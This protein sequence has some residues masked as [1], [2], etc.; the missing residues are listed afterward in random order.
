MAK[1]QAV[2]AKSEQN[3]KTL[4]DE[5]AN[6]TI[7]QEKLAEWCDQDKDKGMC[8][9][10][11]TAV[12]VC[13]VLK[14]A[15]PEAVDRKALAA[16]MEEVMARAVRFPTAGLMREQGSTD[17][18]FIQKSEELL[19]SP[20]NKH[21]FFDLFEQKETTPKPKPLPKPR[22]LKP[23]PKPVVLPLFDMVDSSEAFHQRMKESCATTRSRENGCSSAKR[24]EILCQA[25]GDAAMEMVG[26]ETLVSKMEE[27]FNATP[28]LQFK[29]NAR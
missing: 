4:G 11:N 19:G 2:I 7:F 13:P 23:P 8:R 24:E 22:V 21:H 6:T 27:V 16:K 15:A 28:S 14:T 20:K 18:I 29:T 9:M 12:H 5:F 10:I 1:I 17:A 26:A 25:L 3:F